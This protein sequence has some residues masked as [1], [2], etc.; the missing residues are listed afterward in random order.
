MPVKVAEV[1]SQINTLGDDSISLNIV[2][3]WINDAIAYMNTELGAD[4]PFVEAAQ[5]DRGF[6]FPDKWVLSCIV[7]FGVARL[8]QMDSSVDEASR[9][10]QQFN[11]QLALMKYKYT[12]PDEYKDLDPVLEDRSESDIYT[13]PALRHLGW[14]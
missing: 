3:N 8:K 11:D 10:Y 2:V 5:G 7:P 13:T 4:F 14:F 9:F 12:V 6:A 1:V